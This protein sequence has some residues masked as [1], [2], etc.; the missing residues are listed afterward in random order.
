MDDGHKHFGFGD[1]KW[2]GGHDVDPNGGDRSRRGWDAG[3]AFVHVDDNSRRTNE[4]N[5]L[6]LSLWHISAF[7]SSDA[8]VPGGWAVDS[9]S[10]RSIFF[11][12][13]FSLI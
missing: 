6:S 3:A 2:Y 9:S 13:S 12:L 8:G 1:G 10:V 11:F 4:W 5:S 7:L